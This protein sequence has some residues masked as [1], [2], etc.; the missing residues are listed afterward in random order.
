M[1]VEFRKY[2]YNKIFEL[3]KIELQKISNEFN[4]DYNELEKTYLSDFINILN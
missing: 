3:L 4:L 2:Y 1:I